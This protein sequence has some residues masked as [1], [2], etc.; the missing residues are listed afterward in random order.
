[1][2]YADYQENL[3]RAKYRYEKDKGYYRKKSQ[4]WKAKNPKRYAW[5]GQRNTSKQRGVEFNLTFEQW[6]DWW[7]DD[8]DNRGRKMLQLCMCRYGDT[9]PYE[10]GNIYKATNAENKGPPR[11]KDEGLHADIPF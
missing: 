4:R 7:G 10:L 9:G 11:E 5:L 3:D 1:M 2:P 8:F 6:R